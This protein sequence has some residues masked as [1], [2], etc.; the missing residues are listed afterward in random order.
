MKRIVYLWL[1]ASV[2]AAVVVTAAGAQ[3]Q[4]QSLGD[5]ARSL[6]KQKGQKAPDTKKFEDGTIPTTD[7][8][9]VVGPPPKRSS[10][11]T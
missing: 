4:S 8:L 5:Y 1:V 9:S 6:R 7:T 11:L 2:M 3:S 10:T